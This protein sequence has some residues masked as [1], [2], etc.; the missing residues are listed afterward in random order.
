MNKTEFKLKANKNIDE[1]F[2]KVENL[3]QKKNNLSSSL[4]E[5]Y[6]LK[7]E[8]LNKMKKELKKKYDAV[9]NSSDSNWEKAKKE[10]SESFDHYKAGFTEL[11][12]F[13]K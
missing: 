11:S 6:D 10:F 4:K 5:Q 9:Q 8:A 13:F 2:E 1:I 12:K 3:N 7:I